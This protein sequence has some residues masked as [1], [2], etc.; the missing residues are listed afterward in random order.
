M[1]DC[2][3][4]TVTESEI[5]ELSRMASSVW[6]EHYGSILSMDQITYMVQKFQ[7]APAIRE[8]LLKSGYEYYWIMDHGHRA[9][10]CAI[11][12]LDGTLFLSK[13]YLLKE[14]RGKGLARCTLGELEAR[15]RQD[16]LPIIW[17]TVNRNNPSVEVYRSLGFV[18]TREQVADIGGGYVMDDY[19][20]EYSVE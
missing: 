2:V 13:L 1:A 14:A 15:C 8:Q 3:L 20:M 11:Q 7:S 16:A 5:D 12:P 18:K 9:G 4:Q 6:T 17:L 10:Y 19:I